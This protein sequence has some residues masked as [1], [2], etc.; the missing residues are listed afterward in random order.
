[1]CQESKIIMYA[2]SVLKDNLKI[3]LA[4]LI[5]Q[6]VQDCKL[7]TQRLAFCFNNPKISTAHEERNS[8]GVLTVLTAFLH[9]CVR[10][11]ITF[12]QTSSKCY[13]Q[14][15]KISIEHFK[16]IFPLFHNVENICN[17]FVQTRGV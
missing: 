13:I 9:L 12:M 16:L 14:R 1:M 10:T 5:A 2:Q 15:H 17:S 7:T 3:D 4:V 8:T 11:M 6:A